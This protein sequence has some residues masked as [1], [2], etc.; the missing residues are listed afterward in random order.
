MGPCPNPMLPQHKVT[1]RIKCEDNTNSS[2]KEGAHVCSQTIYKTF[3]PQEAHDSNGIEEE[4]AVWLRIAELKH[5]KLGMA[6]Q[7]LGLP[8]SSCSSCV[9]LVCWSTLD[10]P[11]LQL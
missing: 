5:K 6:W 10:N 4:L 3:S 7:G 1:D 11:C 9:F 2:M 8:M